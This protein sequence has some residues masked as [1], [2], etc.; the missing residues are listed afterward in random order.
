M[1]KDANIYKRLHQ[2]QFE[3]G[4]LV[5]DGN[6]PHYENDYV[7][8]NALN[9]ALAPH[10]EAQNLMILQPI[11]DMTLHTIIMDTDD[12]EIKIESSIRL[13][14]GETNPQRIGSAISYYRRY[15]LVS[16]LNLQAEDDDGNHAAKVT[17]S[18][19]KRSKDYDWRGLKP[20]KEKPDDQKNWL[21]TS[22]DD[23]QRAINALSMGYTINEIRNTWKISTDNAHQLLAEAKAQT[24]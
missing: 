12:P 15:S 4:K 17:G 6:N 8:L 11:K 10:L 3:I 14:E 22:D 1:K 23:W 24:A 9:A 18:K 16:M 5:K 21:E 13:P 20:I 2:L 19:D 7:T